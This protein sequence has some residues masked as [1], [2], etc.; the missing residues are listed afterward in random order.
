M[1][2]NKLSW[3][4]LGGLFLLGLGQP[5]L[6]CLPEPQDETRFEGA[7]EVL[8]DVGAEVVVPALDRFL[9]EADAL[10]DALVA[11][12]RDAAQAAFLVAT[13]TWQ[14]LEMMQMGPA[15]SSLQATGGADLRDEI[16]SWPT[17]NPCR[18]DQVTATGEYADEG[19]VEASLVNSYGLD[20][21]EYLLFAEA[22]VNSCPSIVA[23]N[24]GGV[25]DTLG[26]AEIASRR[27][28][29]ALVAVDGVVDT[30]ERLRDEWTEPGGFGTALASPGDESSPFVDEVE[31]LNAVF[32]AMLYLDTT[33]KSAKLGTPLGLR[34]ETCSADCEDRIEAPHSGA[35]TEWVV[36][37]LRG[38]RSMFTGGTGQG[39]DDLLRNLGEEELAER[40]LANTDAAIAIGEV[41]GSLSE[42]L[43]EQPEPGVELHEAIRLVTVDLKG[44]LATLLSLQIPREAA[45]DND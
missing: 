42:L 35:S 39:F 11:G 3:S 17:V 34:P 36:A 16:Y 44:D 5:Y 4:L 2:S 12:D 40:I 29:Y 31:A 33:T 14:E 6:G 30:A 43:P 9:D 15:G 8:V 21:V 38:F 13:A 26:L 45:G 32:A 25:W 7:A 18:V 20:A 24:E 19:F 1:N 10:R 22:G 23:P 37:N 28:D 27:L 41:T